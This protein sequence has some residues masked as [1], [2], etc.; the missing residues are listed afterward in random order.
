MKITDVSKDNILI[1]PE[2]TS[3]ITEFV[4]VLPK[5]ITPNYSRDTPLTHF[6]IVNTTLSQIRHKKL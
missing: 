3:V 5:D 1:P 2:V 4:D 6:P